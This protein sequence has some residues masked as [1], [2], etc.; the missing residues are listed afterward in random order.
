MPHTRA[1]LLYMLLYSWSDLIY[2]LA[3]TGVDGEVWAT[4]P[5]FKK[6]SSQELVA[7]ARGF[8]NWDAVKADGVQLAGVH[9]EIVAIDGSSM[10]GRLALSSGGGD[11]TAK[12]G[13]MVTARAKTGVVVGIYDEHMVATSCA[14]Q[15]TKV[16]EHIRAFGL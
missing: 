9:Y 7:I 8:D 10:S 13:G 11:N 5:R 6:L 3:T 2:C 1:G 15:V 16:A 14:E 12:R 4:S